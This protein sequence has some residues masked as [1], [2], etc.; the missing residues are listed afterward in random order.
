[1]EGANI[2]L[3]K[4]L[5]PEASRGLAAHKLK[6]DS[7]YLPVFDIRDPIEWIER[8]FY[9][10]ELNGPLKLYPHQTA[11]IREAYRKVNHNDGK[12]DKFAYSIVVWS[13]IKKSA[14]S[15]IT[16]AVALH[17]AYM[18]RWGHI[19]IVANDL[20]QADSRVAYYLRRAIEM[21][22]GPFGD[23]KQVRYRTYVP[24]PART[25]IEA[26]PIDPG[27]EAGGN[28]DL[29]IFSELWAAK[30]KAMIQMWTEMTLSPTKYGRSQRWIETYAGH[31]GESPILENLYHQGV[32]EGVKLDLSYEDEKTGQWHDLSDLEVYANGDLLCM[33]NN[34]PRLPWQTAEYY[35]SEQRALFSSEFRRVHRN[36]WVSSEDSFVAPEWWEACYSGTMPPL[37]PSDDIIVA[38]DAA[39]S[40]DCFGIVATRKEP[41]DDPERPNPVNVVYHRAWV[42][43]KRGK[44]VY[45]NPDDPNDTSTPEGVVRWLCEAYNVL[46][47]VYDEYQL[48]DFCGRLRSEGLAYFTAFN[49]GKARLIADKQLHDS[50]RERGIRHKE[51]DNSALTEHIQNANAKSDG[52]SKLRIVKRSQNAKVDLA[53][54]LSMA[55]NITNKYIK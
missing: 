7:K 43:P 11:V 29:I 18:T 31:H 22:P 41:S 2:D 46:V 27:G 21:N 30:H 36:E 47:V 49:Q 6:R 3:K 45:S 51:P 39:V 38:I 12:G 42:P 50:I 4:M 54:C 44:I 48:H 19:K 14:K 32:K 55:N 25:T 40:G 5:S 34:R 35:A 33:W 16:A 26:I 23:V 28:D 24:S 8:F 15:T 1:M 53:V 37:L 17:R 52:E 20:K 9:I 13:D 10:P